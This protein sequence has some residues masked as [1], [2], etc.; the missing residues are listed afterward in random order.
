[1]LGKIEV[2]RRNDQ[3][4][5]LLVTLFQKKKRKKKL[6]YKFHLKKPKRGRSRIYMKM[7]KRNI[8]IV[9]NQINYSQK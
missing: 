3:R 2:K 6:G 5:I 4:F 8:S 1:M 9:W 7:S